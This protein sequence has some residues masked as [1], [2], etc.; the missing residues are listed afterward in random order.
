MLGRAPDVKFLEE[1]K[2]PTRSLKRALLG[3]LFQSPVQHHGEGFAEL[4]SDWVRVHVAI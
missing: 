2:D 4:V 1:R 3:V